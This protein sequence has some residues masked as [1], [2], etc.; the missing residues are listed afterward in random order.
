MHLQ[1]TAT[2][3]R[4]K[5]SAGASD[6]APKCTIR[7]VVNDSL[8]DSGERQGS[9]GRLPVEALVGV[10]ETALAKALALAAQAGRWEIVV[11]LAEELATRRRARA[12]RNEENAGSRNVASKP[13][14]T[15][16]TGRLDRRGRDDGTCGAR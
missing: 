15:E 10:V 8:D 11:Q 12:R 13:V 6:S 16:D 5:G 4:V 3:R 9:D 14:S 2:N 1:Q 7:C